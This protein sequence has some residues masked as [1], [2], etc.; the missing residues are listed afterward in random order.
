MKIRKAFRA[1]KIEVWSDL[2]I[3]VIFLTSPD[4]RLRMQ[5]QQIILGGNAAQICGDTAL[6][7]E[8]ADED[9][10]ETESP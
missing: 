2:C 5:F 10:D 6:E 1:D 8:D 9:E 3:R 4:P 7:D